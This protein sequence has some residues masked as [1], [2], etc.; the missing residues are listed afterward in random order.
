MKTATYTLLDGSKGTIEYDEKAPC[1]HCGLPVVEA[2]VG[3]T[4]VCP[5]CDMGINR[6]G[7]H[8]WKY[9]KATAEEYEAALR[10]Y[11]PE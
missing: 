7:D 1:I 5:W 11:W 4:V 3:G 10:L 8:I 2:S 9:R 6:T